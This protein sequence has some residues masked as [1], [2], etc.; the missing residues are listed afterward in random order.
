MFPSWW[1]LPRNSVD[2]QIAKTW[3]RGF[4]TKL[5][6]QN[7]LNAAYRIYQDNNS[8]NEIEDQEALIQRYKVGTQFSVSLSYKLLKEN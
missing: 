2:V 8:D 3:A 6:I 7:A 5:N 4:E 1:E